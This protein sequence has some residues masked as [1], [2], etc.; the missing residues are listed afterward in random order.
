MFDVHIAEGAM[1]Q[2]QGGPKKDSIAD[3]YYNQ[4]AEIH[5]VDRPTLDTCLAILQ[6]NPELA[7][8]VYEKVMEMMDK[9][10]VQK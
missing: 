10:R 3:L 5:G 2:F 9:A 6:R 8:E 7:K 1:S 4:V